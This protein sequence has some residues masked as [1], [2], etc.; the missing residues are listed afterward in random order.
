MYLLL[1]SFLIKIWT[2]I[3]PNMSI[4]LKTLHLHDTSLFIVFYLSCHCLCYLCSCNST[5][6]KYK[7]NLPKWPKCLLVSLSHIFGVK[8][9]SN[10]CTPHSTHKVIFSIKFFWVKDTIFC[11]NEI[12]V[13]NRL[14]MLCYPFPILYLLFKY[15]LS[16]NIFLWND[17]VFFN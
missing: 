11:I 8:F 6:G 13:V 4:M 5:L 15:V 12:F 2:L 10:H 16:Q 14:L 9:L 3:F 7:K 1:L 17:I